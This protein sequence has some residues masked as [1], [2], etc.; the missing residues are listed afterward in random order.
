MP[1]TQYN[2]N[3][4]KICMRR[5][6]NPVFLAREWRR[7]LDD[8]EYASPAAL[9]RHLKVS[10]ARI[11]QI[12]NLLRLSPDVLEIISSLGD[13]VRGLVVSER[14]LRP[15]LILTTEQQMLRVKIMLSK[16]N[17]SSPD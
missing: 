4:I 10:R 13:P 8:G 11:T 15:L 1:V 7:A 17:N 6:R 12:M 5:Y 16:A 2:H 14:S 3:L 9:S